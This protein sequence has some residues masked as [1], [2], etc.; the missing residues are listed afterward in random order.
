[1]SETKYRVGIIGCGS[2]A[3]AHAIGYQGVDTVEIVAIADPVDTARNDF[4]NR[5]D[6]DRR[7]HDA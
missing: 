2:I 7:Y 6:I 1:M 5:Y 3:N 4:G